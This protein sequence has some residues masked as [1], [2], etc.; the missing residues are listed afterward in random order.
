MTAPRS[1]AE[2]HPLNHMLV[3]VPLPFLNFRFSV[4]ATPRVDGGVRCL[5]CRA[6]AWRV[7]SREDFLIHFRWCRDAQDIWKSVVE[8]KSRNGK[9]SMRLEEV[10]KSEWEDERLHAAQRA[11]DRR[12]QAGLLPFIAMFDWCS[13][14]K[15]RA[16]VFCRLEGGFNH[17]QSRAT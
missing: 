16:H 10:A 6:T 14:E 13:T 5:G 2:R 17:R 4:G 3:T 11:V 15:S 1:D 7:F 12:K 8:W 9:T